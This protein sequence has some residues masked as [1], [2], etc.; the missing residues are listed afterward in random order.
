M[1]AIAASAVLIRAGGLLVIGLL[2]SLLGTCSPA[3]SV[4]DQVK[5]IGVLRV[6]TTNS[7]STYY[8][9]PA[10][11]TGFQYELVK[12]FAENLG[13]E[14]E[15][16]T[17]SSTSRTLNAVRRGRAHLSVGAVVITP[18]RTK[19][20]RFSRPVMSVVPQLVYR[21]GNRRPNSAGELRGKLVVPAGSASVEYLQGLKKTWPDLEWTESED[22]DTEALL[23]QVSE[24]V[25]DYTISPSDV[26][27]INKRYYP[28]LRSAFDLAAAQDVAWA[29]PMSTDRSLFVR[30]QHYLS[31]LSESDLAQ[32]RDRYFGHVKQVNYVGALKLASDAQDRLPRY[33]ALFEE[34]GRKYDMDWR[35]LAAIGYQESHWDPAAVSPTGVRGIMQLTSQTAKFLK[36]A[37]RLDPAQSIMG[38]ARYIRRLKDLIDEDVR[39]PDRTWLALSAYNLGYG[40]LID[41]RKITASRG[42]DPNR[43]IDVQKSLPLLTQPRWYNKTR[44]GYARGHEAKTYVGN[45]R[46]YYDML[47][48]LFDEPSED[49]P[50]VIEEDAPQEI[51]LRPEEPL[52]IRSPVL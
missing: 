19:R 9:G 5:A 39:D 22:L 45:V 10:G 17:E 1:R 23:V 26:L 29:F 14:L 31:S 13:V 27:S 12:G 24:G 44:H 32:L 42:G 43:W 18:G 49:A 20:W 52:N 33:R 25:I 28:M 30:G 46:T 34:A 35:L 8:E 7:P 37:D 41:V 50:A 48:Y 16:I 2:A 4:L 36:V 38:G 11:P 3:V 21:R 6:A 40:H 15:L 47:V 51:E